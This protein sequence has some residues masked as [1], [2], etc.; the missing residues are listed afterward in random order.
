MTEALL[1]NR[2]DVS[3]NAALPSN[4][5]EIRGRRTNPFG[6]DPQ[7]DKVEARARAALTLGSIIE[8][9]LDRHAAVRLKPKTLAE[10]RR[11]LRQHWRPLHFLAMHK[12]ERRHI[13]GHL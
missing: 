12:V 7:A 11:Y 13:A 8:R 4:N 9:Y 6:G 5:G 10:T 1:E 3:L 2:S